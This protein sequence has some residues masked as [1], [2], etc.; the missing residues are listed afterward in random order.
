MGLRCALGA[1]CLVLALHHHHLA[2]LAQQPQP[3]AGDDGRCLDTV[4]FR[5]KN[6]PG[7]RFFSAALTDTGLDAALEGPGPYL[8]FA[9]DDAAFERIREDAPGV[10]QLQLARLVEVQTHTISLPLSLYPSLSLSLSPPLSFTLCVSV[11]VRRHCSPRWTHSLLVAV[12]AASSIP[13]PRR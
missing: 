8:V 7:L 9:P 5:V 13:T 3:Q 6:D 12:F 4:I 11:C 1:V 2:V 10:L